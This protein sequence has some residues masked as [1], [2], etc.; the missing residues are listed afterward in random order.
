VQ[1]QTG[2]C[3]LIEDAS[4]GGLAGLRPALVRLDLRLKLAVESLRGE[5]TERARD[6]FRGLY[7]TEN[8]VDDLL[9]SVPSADVALRQ[10]A[11]P[12]ARASPRLERLALLFELEPFDQ[13]ALLV[14]LAPDLD[15]RYERL[16]AY[17]QDDVTRRRPTVD[18]IL[19]LL[20]ASLDDRADARSA[21]SPGGRLL[22]RGLLAV[23]GDDSGQMSLLARPLRVDERIVEYMLGSDRLDP[24]VAA[25][26]RLF[27]AGE[28]GQEWVLP[29]EIHD[30]L[31]SILREEPRGPNR[32]VGPV[33]Y[34]HG[35]AASGKRAMA[36]AACVAAGQPL[37]LM[38]LPALLGASTDRTLPGLL[39]AVTREALLQ[40]AV[41]ALDGFDSVLG[42]E[43]EARASRSVLRRLLAEQPGP[44]MLIGEQRW[45]PA[46]WLPGVAAARVELRT[47]EV[48]DRVRLWRSRLDG[49]L[50][51]GDL[52]ALAGRFRLVDDD[53]IRAVAVD[54]SSR[55]QLRGADRVGP[56]DFRLA[57]RAIA[58]PPLEG[59]ARHVEPRYAWDDI[60]LPSDGLVQLEELCARLRHQGTVLE[61][62]GYGRKHARR[63]GITALF[64]GQPG[65][66]K[67]MAA[68]IVAGE[69]G[70]DLYRIDLSAV[71]SKYIGETEKNLEKIFRAADQGE[72]VL[73]FDEADAIFGKRSEVRDA[74]DRYANVEVAYLLQRLENYDGL[75]VLTTNLRGNID[76][77]FIRRL[78]CV[79][80]FPLPEEAERLRIWRLALPAQAPL[81]D[82]VDLPFL[83]RKF[84]LAGGH[85]RNIAL[86][87]GFLAASDAAQIHMRHLL[88][89]TRR[90][91]QKLGKLV[92]EAD[93]E[94]YYDVRTAS[95]REGA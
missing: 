51:G 90:E 5:L 83:A 70:L 69:L 19:H 32:H 21:L 87:A 46:L 74:R 67:T 63:G 71:V 59:L 7:I 24:R 30:G 25:H 79:M 53:A 50:A 81:G 22:G 8:E 26:G 34:L 16:Y 2:R 27:G 73:L 85:I 48:S 36:R 55:A 10:L 43:P 75:A 23:L 54:A 61:R 38:D 92:A 88:R 29:A 28:A 82:D 17:L 40:G 41:L 91:Y 57:A 20:A 42:D 60:V 4:G 84:K 44:T 66:G 3:H 49:Q 52:D 18:L 56:E 47:L 95:E 35:A 45:E 94:P 15:L 65:T 1:V 11:A 86:T 37:L 31:V 78:D 12:A 58:T 13:D 68:E 6:P 76:E 89:A 80:E 33:I 62:W 77:A 39:S 64:A 9:A 14:C 72:A 93:F